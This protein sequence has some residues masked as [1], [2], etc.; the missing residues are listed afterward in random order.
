MSQQVLLEALSFARADH[1]LRNETKTLPDVTFGVESFD[2]TLTLNFG[3]FTV[4]HG[5]AAH[6][7]SM[8][9]CARAM[10]PQPLGPN[11]DVIFV[12][13]GNN[14]DPYSISNISVEQGLDPENVLT[15]IHVSRAFT[16]HQLA[17]LILDKL[18]IAIEKFEARFVIVSDITQL[19]CDPDVRDDDKDDSLQIFVKAVRT[20]RMLTRQHRCLIIATNLEKRSL[21]MERSLTLGAHVSA[22]IE[23]NASI[24]RLSLLKHPNS[25]IRTTIAPMPGVKILESYLWPH[26]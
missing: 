9:L 26:P 8:L 2:S 16:H 4:L 5:K 7:V 11:S 14:F 20:L 3:Q 6:T 23:Q 12:D 17:C 13:G 1:L 24:T 19:F 15:R 10:L 25:S 22:R 18:S 21:Q